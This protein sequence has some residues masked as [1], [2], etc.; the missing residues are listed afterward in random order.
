M[1]DNPWDRVTVWHK[2][3][4]FHHSDFGMA[5]RSFFE[6]VELQDMAIA[7]GSAVAAT[8]VGRVFGEKAVVVTGVGIDGQAW[9]VICADPAM[10]ACW[11]SAI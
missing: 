1:A 2:L 8:D 11:V 9:R 4:A 5:V 10:S 6:I 7:S 3:M